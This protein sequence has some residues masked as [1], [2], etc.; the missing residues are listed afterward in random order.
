[1]EWRTGWHGIEWRSAADK[2]TNMR[3]F[4]MLRHRSSCFVID[5]E[6]HRVPGRGYRIT[7]TFRITDNMMSLAEF[8]LKFSSNDVHTVYKFDVVGSSPA[9]G[10][11]TSSG[12]I[13]QGK[14]ARR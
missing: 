12:I 6:S 11:P 5:L 7:G 1:M 13:R 10:D 4:Y 14:K 8:E 2:A 3:L 9:P